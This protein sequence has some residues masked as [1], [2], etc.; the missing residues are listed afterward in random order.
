MIPGVCL[1]P[2]DECQTLAHSWVWH[3]LR[4]ILPGAVS[5]AW[6][7]SPQEKGKICKFFMSS[8]KWKKLRNANKLGLVITAARSC[9]GS[10]SSQQP[11]GMVTVGRVLAPT[12]WVT[13]LSQHCCPAQCWQCPGHNQD[14][15]ATVTL[16]PG[17]CWPQPWYKPEGNTLLPP[18]GK[19]PII[20]CAGPDASRFEAFSAPLCFPQ[21]AA[22][23][24]CVMK[25]CRRVPTR[26][27]HLLALAEA[28]SCG[29]WPGWPGCARAATQGPWAILYFP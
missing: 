26:L 28:A 23:A 3:S 12:P 5:E 1:L 25:N 6:L 27:R 8:L 19:S 24:T 29:S 10:S 14:T 17:S 7:E 18:H 21:S 9:A 4:E 22:I 20:F 11:F 2:P 13:L 16:V 15:G